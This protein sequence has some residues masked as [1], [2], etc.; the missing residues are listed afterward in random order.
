MAT[1]EKTMREFLF[2][3]QKWQRR[4][5]LKSIADVEV[6]TSHFNGRTNLR[7]SAYLRNEKDELAKDENDELI[8]KIAIMYYCD[9]EKTCRASFEEVG[10]FLTDKKAI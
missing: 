10:K 6:A 7:V 8:C 9:D 4:A 3:A 2:T 5:A 1:S